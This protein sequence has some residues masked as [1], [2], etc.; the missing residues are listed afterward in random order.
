MGSG[1]GVHHPIPDACFSP[2]DETIVAGGAWSVALRQITPRGAGA[3]HP[4]DTVKHAAIIDARYASWLVGQQR[5]NHAP[6]EVGQ[7]ISA[8]AE[9]E[10]SRR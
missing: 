5:L 2:S 7:I 4:K 9:P 3:Q 6:L 8:H 10:S 1:D